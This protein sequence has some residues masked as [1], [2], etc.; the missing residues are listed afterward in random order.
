MTRR[1]TFAAVASA[2][3]AIAAAPAAADAAVYSP[4]VP[5]DSASFAQPRVE[6]ILVVPVRFE[7]EPTKSTPLTV[8]EMKADMAGF[9]DYFLRSSNQN[10]DYKPEVASWVTIPRSAAIGGKPDGSESLEKRV[11]YQWDPKWQEKG[12]PAG[13]D[14]STLE[15]ATLAALKT[16]QPG[17]DQSQFKRFF[18]VTP[19]PYRGDV[20]GKPTF[21]DSCPAGLGYHNPWLYERN[22]GASLHEWMHAVG[23]NHGAS[24][25]CT[26]RDVNVPLGTNCKS[27]GVTD[28]TDAQNTVAGGEVLAMNGVHRLLTGFM[29][30]NNLVTADPAVSAD[31]TITNI[32]ET[33]TPGTKQILRVPR[34]DISN[35]SDSTKLPYYYIDYQRPKTGFAAVPGSSDSILRGVT[36][37]RGPAFSVGTKAMTDWNGLD[38]PRTVNPTPGRGTNEYT[39]NARSRFRSTDG[40]GFTRLDPDVTLKVGQSIWDPKADLTITT[41]SLTSTTAT[42]NVRPGKPTT[43]GATVSLS[44][45]VLKAEQTSSTR[46]NLVV[47]KDASTG[48]FFVSDYGNAIRVGTGCVIENVQTASCSGTPTSIELRGGTGDDTLAVGAS[49]GSIPAKLFGGSG[50]DSLEGGSGNDTLDGGTGADAM[51]GGEGDGDTVTYATRTAGVFAKPSDEP[52]DARRVQERGRGEV[53]ENDGI[54]KETENVNAP[55]AIALPTGSI[56][57]PQGTVHTNDPSVGMTFTASNQSGRA[58]TYECTFFGTQ[59]GDWKPCTPGQEFRGDLSPRI[60]EGRRVFDFGVRSID[61]VSGVPLG[62]VAYRQGQL[63]FDDE[64]PDTTVTSEPSAP[65]LSGDTARFEFTSPNLPA[66]PDCSD[67]RAQKGETC[68]SFEASIDDKPWTKVESPWTTASLTGGA[69]KIAI[70]ARDLAGN[71]DPTPYEETFYVIPQVAITG[72]PADNAWMNASQLPVKYTFTSPNT[73][74]ASFKCSVDSSA[75]AACGTP[76]TLPTPAADGIVRFGVRSV[77][78]ILH[79]PVAYRNVGIDRVAPAQPLVTGGPAA[80]STITTT[81]ATFTYSTE[82]ATSGT[83]PVRAQYLLDSG[84]WTD[85]NGSTTLSGL[86]GGA[87]TFSVR[88]IDEAGNASAPVTRTFTVNAGVAAGVVSIGAPAPFSG[89]VNLTNTPSTALDWIH[90]R[91]TG[92]TNYDRSGNAQKIGT[93]TRLGSAPVT[94]R[95]SSAGTFAGAASGPNNLGVTTGIAAGQGFRFV[96]SNLPSQSVTLR[97][98]VGVFGGSSVPA[99]AQIEGQLKATL[100]GKA[101][102]YS[103]KVSTTSGQS[104]TSVDRVITVQFRR[105]NAGDTLTLDWTKTGNSNQGGSTVLYAA[106]LH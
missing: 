94:T 71:V 57:S 12:L 69:H 63:I 76:F 74:T 78:G 41:K 7:G 13:F 15:P 64:V 84:V 67:W 92:S 79:G 37:R 33:V 105:V 11:C 95:A 87:H 26:E 45:G 68:V 24:L 106:S 104:T 49:A 9:R 40:R 66:E 4:G 1:R 30:T 98:Y 31:Y 58:V 32:E 25:Q 8:D 83:A 56:P 60:A 82:I 81:T 6:P 29:P 54:S 75:S 39:W 36:I 5:A 103:S 53:G 55:T 102:V 17:I 2:F 34:G 52:S 80:G 89:T 86:S 38:V 10:V 59:P 61:A 21:D 88:A 96:V 73:P 14:W 43:A 101:A 42:V 93:W 51:D 16:Q 28:A 35:D 46:A 77:S 19:N 27:V 62:I 48:R 20:D 22:I 65:L 50:N 91:G 44:G 3:A 72:G 100:S 99:Q 18:F 85:G 90:W 47:S 97:L 23:I 70:R